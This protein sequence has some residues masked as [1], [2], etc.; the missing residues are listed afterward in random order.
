MYARKA[1]N[2]SVGLNLHAH[3]E[4]HP[5][6][7]SHKTRDNN[8]FK[9]NVGFTGSNNDATGQPSALEHYRKA[10]RDRQFVGNPVQPGATRQSYQDSDIFGTKGKAETV[11]RAVTAGTKDSRL[12]QSNTFARSNVMGND[13]PALKQGD[14][15]IHHPIT[16]RNERN[17]NS[18]VFAGAKPEELRRKN[19]AR[20]DAGRGGLYGDQDEQW[21][22]KQN[23]AGAFKRETEVKYQVEVAANDRKL[24]E[25]HGEKAQ[26][27][28]KKGDG[29]LMASSADW[30][31]PH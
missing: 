20:G 15:N 24:K 25:L 18:N 5:H 29:A 12:R 19:L 26:N 30:R 13:E 4:I 1:Y 14:G 17:W 21:N 27:A 2:A 22:K 23:L 11:Q 16:T 31:N 7:P 8:T 9:S 28:G 10:T 6:Q 3:S